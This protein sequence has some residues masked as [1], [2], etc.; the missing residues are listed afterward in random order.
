[1]ILVRRL[2]LAN[3]VL[4]VLLAGHVADHALRQ[5][6]DEQLSLV[7]SLPGLLGTLAVF[8]SLALV[9]AGYR[10]A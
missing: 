4:A 10:H 2:L 5:P 6:A 1:M 7:A 9:L 8:L 3:L